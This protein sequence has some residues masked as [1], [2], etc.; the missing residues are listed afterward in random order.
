MGTKKEVC[1][2]NK[3]DHVVHGHLELVCKSNAEVWNDELKKS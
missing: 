1:R 3:T 2:C